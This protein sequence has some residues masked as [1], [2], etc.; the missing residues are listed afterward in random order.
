M[1]TTVTGPQEKTLRGLIRQGRVSP[2]PVQVELAYKQF[3]QVRLLHN[4][5]KW[6]HGVGVLLAVSNV[7]LH[8]C[9]RKPFAIGPQHSLTS[10]QERT[11]CHLFPAHP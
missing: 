9:K 6:Q 10:L 8:R 2:A 11:L 5:I 3:V 1:K 7:I 4:A